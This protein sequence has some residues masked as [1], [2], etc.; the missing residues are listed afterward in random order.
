MITVEVFL[1]SRCYVEEDRCCRRKSKTVG[2]HIFQ[3]NSPA[4]QYERGIEGMT[5]ISIKPGFYDRLSVLDNSVPCSS[6]CS[7]EDGTVNR[8]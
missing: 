2:T 8:D 7:E 4:E 5:D 6:D 3:E 1:I